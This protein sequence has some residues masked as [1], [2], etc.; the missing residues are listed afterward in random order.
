M[1]SLYNYNI[2]ISFKA[3]RNFGNRIKSMRK[4]LDELTNA[5]PSPIPSPDINA[6]SPE[7]DNDFVLPGEQNFYNSMNGFSSYVNSSLPFDIS[8]FRN[9]SS[10]P[11][12]Q[13]IQSIQVIQSRAEEGAAPISDFYKSLIPSQLDAFPPNPS[14]PTFGYGS[15]NFNGPP[16]PPMPVLYGKTMQ[17]SMQQNSFAPPPPPPPNMGYN[18]AEQM[19]GNL[20]MMP[21]PMPPALDRSTD[22]YDPWNELPWNA[23][24]VNILT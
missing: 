12:G 15:K 21:P 22:E 14:G 8:D 7:P 4:K 16:P 11:D 13:P 10:R 20:P 18:P 6:P 1:Q 5:L 19:Y 3:Y 2:F 17:Q 23:S 9:T 24:Q